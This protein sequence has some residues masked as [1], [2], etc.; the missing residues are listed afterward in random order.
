MLM[1][2]KGYNSLMHVFGR[3]N[4]DFVWLEFTYCFV[5]LGLEQ[6]S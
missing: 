2:A 3:I 1:T 5:T 4:Y 6:D